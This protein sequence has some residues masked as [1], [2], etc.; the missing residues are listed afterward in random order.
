MWKCLPSS[1]REL[2]AAEQEPGDRL[3][4][5]QEDQLPLTH[6]CCIFGWVPVTSVCSLQSKVSLYSRYCKKHL[7]HLRGN[8]LSEG[9]ELL[10]LLS[11]GGG[12]I[13]ILGQ[14]RRRVPVPGHA[15]TC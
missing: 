15:Y 14:M 11:G 4:L 3:C 1:P 7:T 9:L 13:H 5:S 12:G 6:F 2:C 8:V 10:C